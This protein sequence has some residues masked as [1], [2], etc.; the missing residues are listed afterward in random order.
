LLTITLIAAF[1]SLVLLGAVYG[2]FFAYS[3]SVAPGLD[4]ADPEKAVEAM[5]GMNIAIVN[6]AFLATFVGPVVTAAVTGV[7]LLSLGE[8]ASGVL[9]LMAAAVYLVGCLVVTGR[10]NVPLNNALESGTS[11]DW[12]QR[13]AEFSPRWRRWNTVRTVSSGAALVLSGAGLYLWGN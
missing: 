5:R 11:T 3:N 2:V 6:P 13:W 9:H 7:L 4:R 8:R 12:R 1:L 10:I